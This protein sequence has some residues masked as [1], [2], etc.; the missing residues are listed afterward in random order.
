MAKYI[1]TATEITTVTR[2]IEATSYDEAERIMT[3]MINEGFDDF[4]NTELEVEAI[5]IKDDIAKSVFQITYNDDG[6]TTVVTSCATYD[7]AVEW[8]KN[9]AAGIDFTITNM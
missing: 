5:G 7:D 8:A 2:E 3:E 6:N 1:V 9:Y 4:D